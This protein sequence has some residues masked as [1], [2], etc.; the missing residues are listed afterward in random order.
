MIVLFTYVVL[1]HLS[2]FAYVQLLRDLDQVTDN[3]IKGNG[4]GE[5][6]GDK[7]NKDRHHVFHLELHVAGEVVF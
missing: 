2:M 1:Q 4:G 3:K 6:V 5:A 7:D